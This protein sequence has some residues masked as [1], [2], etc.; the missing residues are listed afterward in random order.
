MYSGC[1]VKIDDFDEDNENVGDN[2]K[3]VTAFTTCNYA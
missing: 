1:I 3:G 2:R